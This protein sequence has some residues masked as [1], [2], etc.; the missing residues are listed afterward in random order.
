MDFSDL[1]CNVVKIFDDNLN[2]RNNYATKFEHLFVDEMQDTNQVQ[3]KLTKHLASHHNNI[4]AVAREH[5]FSNI[6]DFIEK[7]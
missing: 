7:L 1:I 4:I 3:L 2:V 5:Y 6:R